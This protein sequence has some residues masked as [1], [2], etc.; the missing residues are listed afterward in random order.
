MK[1]MFYWAGIIS[2]LI[3]LP[4]RVSAQSYEQMWKQVE[5]LEQ[6]QLP[7]S[8]IKELQKIYEHAKQEKNMPQMMKAHLTKAS[9]SIDI[10][11]DSLDHE[12]SGLKIWVAEEKDPVYKAILNNLLGYYTLDTGK[13]DEAA[14]DAAI[15]YFRLS[16]QD[17]DI[18]SRKSAADYR[19][20]TVSKELS[21]KYCG[22]NMYQLLARQAISRLSGYFIV[23]PVLAEKIQ[24]EILSIYDELIDFYQQQGMTDARLLLM[25][26]KLN[27]QGND[28]S[29]G[30]VNEK[31]RLTDEQVI[32]LLKQWA[33]EFSASPLCG[34]VYCQL[35][36][37]YDRMQDYTAK[38][39]AA[40]TGLKKYPQSPSANDLKEQ[41]AEVLTPRLMVEI[42]FAYPAREVDLKVK[43]R[44]LTGL[45]VELYRMNLPVT[46]N[47]LKEE[48]TASTVS[49]Y[50]KL[51]GTRHY[52]LA[53]TPDYMET[54][55]LL[56]YKFPTEGIYILKSIPDGHRKYTAY[57]KAYASSLQAI[58]LGLPGGKQEINIIDRL[59]GHPVAG[60]EVAYYHVSQGEGYRL[61]K[62]YPADS[63][64]TVTLTPPDERNWLGINVRKPG[65]DYM[66]ISY[67]GFSGAGY[68][69][70]AS[71]KWEKHASLFTDRAL[72]RPGQ[73]VHVSGIAYEQSGDSIRV[74][75][76]VR[77]DVV[78]RDANRQEI[79]KIS[80]DTDEFGAFYGEFM[81]PETLL[82]GE[83]ELSVQG[84]ENRYI[85][86]DEYK[87]PTFDVVF[88]PY[89]ATYN[90][91]DTVLVSGEA[92]TFA[93][94][95]VGLCRLS[96]KI[97]RSQNEF[98]RIS[99]HE[100]VLA[101]GEVQTD[102]AGNFRFPVFLR[103]PDD[104]KPD[105]PGRYYTYK[106]T[107]EVISLTG[108]VESGTL[109]LPIGQQSVA[110]QIKGLRPKVA[111]EK[112]ETIQVLAMNLNRQPVTLQATYV[113]YALD[114]KGNKTN[115]VCRRTVETRRSFVPD[116]ILAL[117][118]GRYTMEVSALDG[119]GRTCTARQDFILFSLAD[120][121]L[122]VHSPEWFY[123][124]GTEFNDGHPVSLYVGS[125]EKDVYLLYDVF[126]GDKRIESKRMVLNNEIRQFTYPYKPE[127]G[128]GITVNFAF[129]REGK[130]YTK[131]VQIDRPRPEKSLQLKWITFRDK[132]QPGGKEEWQL[133]ITYPDKKAADAQ[134]LATLYDASLD[135]LYVNDW[136]FNLN[137][138]RSTP[139][140]RANLIFS[141]HSIWMY[142]NFPYA[143]STLRGLRWWD[144]YSTLNAPFW[145]VP[146]PENGFRVKQD[147]RMMKPVAISLDAETL[148]DDGFE[149]E[150]GSSIEAVFECSDAVA[151]DDGSPYVPLRQNFAETAFFYP[152]LR[153]DTNG[154]VSLSFTLPESLTEWKFMGLAHT[155]GMD[156]G[157]ITARAKAV[158]PFMVQPNMPRFIRVNDKPVISTGIINLSEENIRGTARMELVDPQTNRVL[159]TRE[160]EFS[161]PAGAT[162]SVSFDL[163]TPDEATVWIC[164]IIAEGGNFS[165][166]EQHYL[167]VLSDKQWVAEAI[168][169]QLNGTESKSV[170]L[171]SLFNDGS[172]TAT[173]KRLTVELTANPDWYAIQALPVIGNPVDED[174]LSWASAYYANSLSVAILDANPR[175][176]QVFESWKI[177]GSPL[178]G[179]LNAKE[180]LKE[181]LLKET[182]WLA[183]A[184][185]E[186]ERKRN[187]ALLFDLNMMSN[188]NRIAVSRLEALQLPDGSWSW[189][190]G[191]TGNRYITT[192]IV[193]MLARLRTM[194][195]STLPVQGMYEKAV[196]YLHTQW[197][198]EYR[199][200]KENE[201]KGNRNGLPGEQ[202]L[203][204]LYICALDEQVAKR[205]DKT[206]YSYMIDRLEAGAPSDVI[207]DRALIAT[208]LH[209]A[210]KKVKAD[211]LARSIL[212]YSVATPEM[213]R[214]FDT[215]KARYS[216]GSYR[217]PTQVVAIEALSGILKEP[218]AIAEM[219]Q[220]LLKQKQMQVW[221]NPVATADAVY[222]FLSGDD[223]RLAENS[224]MKAE[225][226]GTAVVAPDD[227]LGYVRRSFSGNEV[228]ARQIEIAHTGA[229]IG[230]G[231]VYAQCLE[232]MDQLQSAKGNG[233]KITRAYY[234]D[235]KEVS[236]KTDLHV[237]D[238][239]IVRLTVKADRDMD[240]VQ[241]K[242]TRAACMEPKEALSGYRQSDATG[243]YQVMRDASAKFFID[244]LRKGI[245][246]I[247]YKVYIDR[248]GTYQTGIATVQSAYAPEFGGHTK[249]LSVTVR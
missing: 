40:Q 66:E 81:L 171:E 102:A 179:N 186:T 101:V 192:R 200:M 70:P 187:I 128:D 149:V 65:A 45:T 6:K 104:F 231:A 111:R 96:Y 68:N 88:Q 74:F 60:T 134:L 198:D 120:R 137:F 188:R 94:I 121:H 82:P 136:A 173:N 205:A 34:E 195:A 98:W 249:S 89:Q 233:L 105:R 8:A 146:H 2:I 61:V 140:V 3:C 57:G 175:I 238:E 148:S 218:L 12:L 100:T 145:R 224:T 203:H 216:W 108:E 180:E 90:V 55:T 209:K 183:D 239:L 223:N 38:L 159:S 42:P 37:R 166:G 5:A 235:G 95:P 7:E 131:Q 113:V 161:A 93:G 116:D 14:I 163:E 28:I 133:Q 181:L 213:G 178:P 207:Y 39:H 177:Q 11:P 9:L 196:S 107:A 156:Y 228:G 109:S 191:M 50:G 71:R 97:T 230:W 58:F 206:A 132:L 152:A 59:T 30:G 110:L 48:I 91:G 138:P 62:A 52:Q 202:S 47:I 204:Y 15:A 76:R 80:L 36:E 92:K 86:V 16:L 184:L 69:V 67:A 51:V 4:L 160:H 33:E 18:L 85:R 211:E 46:S 35:A 248:P 44:N 24:T 72:Y 17:K 214:Y 106:I 114:E 165:D 83:F 234:R 240:F 27:Y 236:S 208:I 29:R 182:P 54:D 245:V 84:G 53:A 244:K 220:W 122:P 169:V 222:A 247:E 129:M 185:D 31:L 212:E 225:I 112:R 75:S 103:K 170:T 63:K 135:K 201:K 73:V 143:G 130:L 242:D 189:Y 219:K 23:N 1:N 26:D 142:S 176:R 13:R 64:G 162:V 22:D 215:P 124:D 194:G 139:G 150:D 193:E 241:I 210:G 153:T 151:L 20:M 10:T 232:D 123:Q 226:A 56:R 79:G 141:G 78:L 43:Y 199:Q 119:Q 174:A 227:A 49:R 217:I 221:D 127:Y 77:K 154:V 21:G 155:R 126:C 190:K 117:A 172:K 87:R 41:A 147:S 246:Q 157:Q 118:P 167:P 158:K 243:Y 25:L 168:P 164:R 197:L 229:G 144:V 99:D 19:P 115:E 237:G 32:I 125:S